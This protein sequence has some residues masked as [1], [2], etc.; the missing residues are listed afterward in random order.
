MNAITSRGLLILVL[1]CM[2]STVPIIHASEPR[3]PSSCPNYEIIGQ[4]NPCI[5]EQRETEKEVKFVNMYFGDPNT[6]VNGIPTKVEVEAGDGVATLIAVMANSGAFELTGLRGWLYLPVGFDAYG[7]VKGEPAFD[8]YDLKVGRG[9]TFYF[10]FPVKVSGNLKDGIYKAYLRVEYFRSQDIGLS[11]RNFEVEFMLTGRSVLSVKVINPILTPGKENSIEIEVTNIGSAPASAVIAR[12]LN[13]S[14]LLSIGDSIF[15]ISALEP[16]SSSKIVLKAYANPGIANTNQ[17]IQLLLEYTDTYGIRRSITESMS[18]IVKGSTSSADL[19]VSLEGYR[20]STLKDNRLS[21]VLSNI[22]DESAYNVEVR[23]ITDTIRGQPISVIGDGYYRLT[24]VDANSRVSLPLILFATSDAH[25][26]TY[27]IP[28]SIT[29]LDGT[30]GLH[31]VERSISVYALGTPSIRMYELQVTTIGG[32][33]NLSGY[34]LNDGSA[35]ALFTSVDVVTSDGIRST[36][37]AQYLGDLLVNSPLPFNIPISIEESKDS[38]TVKVK[39]TYKD[40]LRNEYE[41]I[42]EDE[43]V[44]IQPAVS[45]VKDSDNLRLVSNQSQSIIVLAGIAGAGVAGFIIGRRS[46]RSS[47]SGGI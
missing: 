3:D 21:I 46:K 45:A 18:V 7:R 33:L 41:L 15:N 25:N 38:Y 47:S 10:E 39:V 1:A 36:L 5:R 16:N 22:G 17:S 8:T 9:D 44:F 20:V 4:D 42:L 30:G 32:G 31:R 6:L 28:L 14:A 23:V 40:A 11:Y 29:Y 37:G 35:D 12:I 43:L 19:R 24:S 13:T 34:L 2:L 26:K 27:D